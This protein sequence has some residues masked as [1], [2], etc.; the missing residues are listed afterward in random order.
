[1]P[2]IYYVPDR[3]EIEARADESILDAALRAG[4]PHTHVCGGKGRCSTCRV[5]I[6]EGLESCSPRSELEHPVAEAL[7][8]APEIRLACQTMAARDVKLRRMVL[9][10]DDVMLADQEDITPGPI[11]EEKQVGILFA[12]IRGFTGFAEALPPYDVVHALNRYFNQM[13]TVI[14][15][16]GGRIDNYMGDGLLALFGVRDP[17]LAALRAVRA[18]LDMLDAVEAMRP[19]MQAVYDNCF[20]IGIGVHYGQVVIGKLGAAGSQRVTAIGDAVNLAARI[21]AV[22]KGAGTNFLISEDTYQQVK[23]HVQVG[24]SVFVSL[25][26]RSGEYALYEVAGL[27]GMD[28]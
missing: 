28:G 13:G 11:G 15:R 14:S 17:N 24:Q 3:V 18:G 22:T 6:F 9:D 21:E 7:C 12:D 10:A 26:G 27:R 1:M 16:H 20:Q 19:Y 5:L 8:F 23:D 4:I 2:S 25:P